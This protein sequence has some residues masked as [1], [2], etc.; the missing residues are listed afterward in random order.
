LT[1]PIPLWRDGALAGQEM[2]KRN[3][4]I[5]RD[6]HTTNS[7]MFKSENFFLTFHPFTFSLSV[8]LPVCRKTERVS[9]IFQRNIVK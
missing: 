3:S 2:K 7:G 1:P 6:V 8:S 5:N 4:I 9:A